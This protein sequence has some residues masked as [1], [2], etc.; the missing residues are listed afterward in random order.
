[1]RIT[2]PE[3]DI[4]LY[5][6][7]FDKHDQLGR[8]SLGKQ[9]SELVEKIEEPL[10]IALNS[11]WG[12]GKTH[13]LKCWVGAHTV[14]NDG[15][16]KTIYFDAFKNDFLD[17][18]LIALTDAI[19]QRKSPDKNSSKA[20]ETLKKSAPKLARVAVRVVAAV[21]TAGASEI[22][23]NVADSALNSANSEIDKISENFWK[24]EDS[25]RRA[26]VDFEK[27]L[28][29]LTKN[30]DG[31]DQKIVIVI[32]ELDRCRPDY[33]LSV[34]E[35]MKHFFQIPNVHFIL[36]VNL[37]ELKNSARARYGAGVNADIY[38]HKF[39]NTYL[40]IPN[41][42]VTSNNQLAPLEYYSYVSRTLGFKNKMML[43]CLRLLKEIGEVENISLRAI[44]RL[45]G[46]LIL[47]PGEIE[48]R[49]AVYQELVIC[50]KIMEIISPN[51]FQKY[52]NRTLDLDDIHLFFN[53]D[54]QDYAG[55]VFSFFWATLLEPNKIYAN[56]V[57]TNV[58]DQFGR[59]PAPK[60]LYSQLDKYLNTFSFKG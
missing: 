28:I 6:E 31:E 18:P 56:D 24:K 11:S 9:L 27:A 33:A 13:F 2:M 59:R 20:I 1:M 60:N 40:E 32:D 41:N 4:K 7:G 23:G 53:V 37:H 58:F 29:A 54:E 14:E 38:L 50:I 35:T 43:T 25:K 46:D 44:E 8:A 36:G 42:T 49:F 15:N 55:Q 47:L 10:V 48:S 3:L 45:V 34:L 52:Q 5:E 26:M 19:I 39:I 51:L 22:V 16:A 17:D 12:N 30:E 57:G 21:A